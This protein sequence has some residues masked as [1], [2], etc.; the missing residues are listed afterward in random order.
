MRSDTDTF[1]KL[2]KESLQVAKIFIMNVKDFKKKT[3]FKNH[4][5][6]LNV[7]LTVHYTDVILKYATAYNCTTF[8]EKNKHR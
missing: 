6:C 4:L 5:F 1:N 7:H 3:V 8:S 2:N